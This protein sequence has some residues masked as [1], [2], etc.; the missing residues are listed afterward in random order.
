MRPKTVHLELRQGSE[1]SALWYENIRH[2][3]QHTKLV[4]TSRCPVVKSSTC[5][6]QGR[7]VTRKH[8]R[9]KYLPVLT[10]AHSP[11]PN[12]GVVLSA[13]SASHQS[14]LSE[15]PASWVVPQTKAHTRSLPACRM[16]LFLKATCRIAWA[17][18]LSPKSTAEIPA[19]TNLLPGNT[20]KG[21]C[22]H[23]MSERKGHQQVSRHYTCQLRAGKQLQPV[24]KVLR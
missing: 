24:C 12:P 20:S 6:H 10:H 16:R 23:G 14:S 17:L 19:T 1:G 5:R 9:F 8:I 22:N 7:L 18:M 3:C 4:R 2:L 11:S 15:Q 21:S 13:S